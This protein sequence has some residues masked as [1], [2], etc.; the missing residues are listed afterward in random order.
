MIDVKPPRT[1]AGAHVD[2]NNEAANGCEGGSHVYG[3]SKISQ[4]AEI[5]GNGLREPQYQAGRDQQNRTV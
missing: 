1:I 2:V 3:H 5:P 4:P